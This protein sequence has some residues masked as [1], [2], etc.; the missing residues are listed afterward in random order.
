MTVE[1]EILTMMVEG[2]LQLA[3]SFVRVGELRC[4]RLHIEQALANLDQLAAL[5]H[6]AAPQISDPK[7]QTP[8]SQQ[9]QTVIEL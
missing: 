1:T 7:P 9:I 2:D 4:T 5:A 6:D 3:Q 8:T